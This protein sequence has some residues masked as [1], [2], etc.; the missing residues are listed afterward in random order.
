MQ[1]MEKSLDVEIFANAEEKQIIK[2]YKLSGEAKING[3]IEYL[4]TF[5]ESQEESKCILFAHH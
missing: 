3:I 4:D 5:F 2:A 1:E